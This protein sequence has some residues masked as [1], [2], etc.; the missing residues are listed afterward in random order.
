MTDL[1]LQV[2]GAFGIA[3][4]LGLPVVIG[5]LVAAVAANLLSSAVGLSDGTVTLVARALGATFAIIASLAS[6]QAGTVDFAAT[7]WSGIAD[8]GT[9]E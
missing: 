8:I 4:L 3:L 1:A 9:A 5:A 2:Q 6:L 7:T